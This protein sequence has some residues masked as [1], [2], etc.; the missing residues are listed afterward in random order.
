LLMKSFK[1]LKRYWRCDIKGAETGLLAGKTVGIKDNIGVAGVPMMN[2][3][4]MLEG[5]TPEFDATLV[6]RILDAGVMIRKVY[7]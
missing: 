7:F 6:T 1:Y 4:K 3:S 2:G 5:F